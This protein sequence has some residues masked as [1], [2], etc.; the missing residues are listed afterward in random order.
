MIK[1]YINIYNNIKLINNK[2]I[3]G[4]LYSISIG[5]MNSKGKYFITLEPSYFLV[6]KNFLKELYDF[7]YNDKKTDILEFN[8]LVMK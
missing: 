1:K 2:K 8:L 4:F 6:K 7:I 3:K 5:I